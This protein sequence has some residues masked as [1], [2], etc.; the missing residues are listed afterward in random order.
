MWLWLRCCA[1][2]QYCLW[3]Y[4]KRSWHVL[5]LSVMGKCILGAVCRL[6]DECS[7]DWNI[8]LPSWKLP[9]ASFHSV[10]LNFLFNVNTLVIAKWLLYGIMS[11]M[12][13]R[14]YRR[15]QFTNT[16]SWGENVGYFVNY[17]FNVHFFNF[18]K[19]LTDEDP[20]LWLNIF[21]IE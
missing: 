13:L 9:R 17:C 18:S 19:L 15:K 6:L 4:L 2:L 3:G 21:Y 20:I 14:K 10:F 12:K 5:S 11:D 8:E 16:Q 1:V 7:N